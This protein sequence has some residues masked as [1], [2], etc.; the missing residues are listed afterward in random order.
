MRAYYMRYFLQGMRRGSLLRSITCRRRSK[1]HNGGQV[2]HLYV[3]RTN[4]AHRPPRGKR[5]A[6]NGNQHSQKQQSLRK[7]TF[8]KT[9]LACKKPPV[10]L[11]EVFMS[12][13]L[14]LTSQGYAAYLRHSRGEA[15]RSKRSAALEVQI[16]TASSKD[17]SSEERRGRLPL[18]DHP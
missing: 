1:E 18:A 2:R 13:L 4:V 5:A 9:F 7:Q 14:L 10:S 8:I 6:W 11:Q 3:K 16:L 17:G 15:L 12:I